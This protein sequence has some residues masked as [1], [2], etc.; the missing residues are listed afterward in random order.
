M[1]AQM[2]SEN[3]VIS[4]LTINPGEE[5]YTAFG[6]S[7]IRVKDYDKGIDRVYNY[8]TV[9]F[10]VPN[11][12]VKFVRGYLNYRLDDENMQD[13]ML[14]NQYENRSVY[15]QVLDLTA[16]EKDKVF[17]FLEYNRLPENKYY[18]Y[19]FFFDNCATRIRDVFQ[20]ELKGNI[21]FDESKY[22][23]KT[24][25]E[26]LKPNLERSPWGR[27]GINLVLGAIADRKS[28]LNE[29]MFLP[30]YMKVA[31][32]NSIIN[33]ENQNKSI[34][35]SANVLFEQAPEDKSILIFTRPGFIFWSV[36]IV[37]LLFTFLEFQRKVR[38]K[39]IDFLVFLFIGTIGMILFLMWFATSHTAVVKNWNLIWAIPTHLF[40]AFMIFRKAKS[41]FL[42][43]YF[44]I[45]GII[46]FSVLPFWSI[47]P[48]QYDL[49]F[50]PLILLSL[51][52]SYQLFRYY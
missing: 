47:I 24:F 32:D 51:V 2:L 42:K 34:I 43:Y 38:Y 5:L 46:S 50:V 8:G 12:Y 25:R 49:A 36:L 22:E 21:R 18:L 10:N 23:G 17:S 1:N 31:F 6:H 16:E 14:R 41:R 40:L 48:Q 27:F 4:L 13:F 26:M 19:D 15:E 39:L 7:A 33:K 20:N 3:A 30:D 45:T 44:L 11:Y 37:V 28:T 52:R 35:K 9:D 29:S